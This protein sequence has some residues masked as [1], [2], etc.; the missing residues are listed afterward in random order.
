MIGHVPREFSRVSRHFLLHGGTLTVAKYLGEDNVTKAW[1][2]R[3]STP[4]RAL[5]LS[6]DPDIAPFSSIRSACAYKQ[7]VLKTG[8]RGALMIQ[9][10]LQNQT[11]RYER[12]TSYMHGLNIAEDYTLSRL[13][14]S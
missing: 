4:V 10:A 9:G 8:R 1:K 11:L 7:A 6:I 12:F 13:P 5:P 3:V 2:C 14:V